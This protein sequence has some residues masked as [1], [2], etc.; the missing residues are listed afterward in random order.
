MRAFKAAAR[1][2]KQLSPMIH[3]TTT[4]PHR[5]TPDAAANGGGSDRTRPS[6]AGATA[7]NVEVE[8]KLAIPKLVLAELLRYYEVHQPAFANPVKLMRICR[9]FRA[10]QLR[11]EAEATAAAPQQQQQQQQQPQVKRKV[12]GPGG[13]DRKG[14]T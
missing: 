7:Q 13:E 1:A 14:E 11:L 4:A 2:P 6:E 10:K 9:A 8:K 5:T 12:A 3:P